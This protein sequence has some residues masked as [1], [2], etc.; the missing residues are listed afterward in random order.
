MKIYLV[1]IK[2]SASN[3]I[4]FIFEI[5]NSIPLNV[6]FHKRLKIEI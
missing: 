4:K 5:K 1:T 3:L 2:G 6:D